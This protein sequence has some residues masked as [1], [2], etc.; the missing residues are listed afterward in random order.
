M[1]GLEPIAVV[2]K[3]LERK[4]SPLADAGQ[5]P[6]DVFLGLLGEGVGAMGVMVDLRADDAGEDDLRTFVAAHLDLDDAGKDDDSDN[7]KS[8]PDLA[9][10]DLQ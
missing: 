8:N 4:A 5:S 3:A 6:D 1:A 7:D 2:A 10:P 9:E